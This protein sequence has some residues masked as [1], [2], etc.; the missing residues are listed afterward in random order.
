MKTPFQIRSKYGN[1]KVEI[2]TIKFDSIKEANRYKELKLLLKAQEITHLEIQ[3]KYELQEKFIDTQ[4]KKHQAITY[5]ADFK[6]FDKRG[7]IL[8]DVKGYR[9]RDYILRIKLL[10]YKYPGILFFEL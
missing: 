2:D 3:P 10:L 4:G 9:T 8:E 1:K 7:C 6:Y 5:T